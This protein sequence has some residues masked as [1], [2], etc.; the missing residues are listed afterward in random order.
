MVD[1][2]SVV[3]T[4]TVGTFVTPTTAKVFGF[5][6]A[7][8]DGIQT[9]VPMRFASVRIWSGSALVQDLIPVRRGGVGYM[10]DR[11]TGALLGNAASSGTF[12][13]GPDAGRHSP[14]QYVEFISYGTQV[15]ADT[16]FVPTSDSGV[17]IE[18][19]S[20][21]M[22]NKGVGYTGPW[23][24]DIIDSSHEYT[25]LLYNGTAYNSLITNWRSPRQATINITASAGTVIHA[26]IG[27]GRSATVNNTTIGNI[28]A[29][30]GTVASPPTV[31][32]ICSYPASVASGIRSR[33]MHFG[34][35]RS[36]RV[37]SEIRPVLMPDGKV[38]LYD[39]IANAYLQLVIQD[40]SPLVDIPSQCINALGPDIN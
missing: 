25:R 16:L 22:D 15:R 20:A 33:M 10:Y 14:L 34:V 9:A 32:I 1:G 36:S 8:G 11:V 23:T 18:S 7:G 27:S 39:G 28:P 3:T 4:G 21:L 35:I 29:P 30:S 12:A 24:A 38:R 5:S 40:E 17:W 26:R 37:A 6:W 13:A 2:T 31:K 19:T